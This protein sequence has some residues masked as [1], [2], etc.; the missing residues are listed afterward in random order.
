MTV[1]GEGAIASF[2]VFDTVLTRL[3]LPPTAVGYLLLQ[4]LGMNGL[5]G[6][7]SL[8]FDLGILLTWKA[9]V[10]ASVTT[11]ISVECKCFVKLM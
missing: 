11:F 1:K 5:L 10:L 8:G 2:D 4:F 6:R 3:V 7:Q 9:A